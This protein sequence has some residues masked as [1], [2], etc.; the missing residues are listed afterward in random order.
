MSNAEDAEIVES[1]EIESTEI[2]STIEVNT[3]LNKALATYRKLTEGGKDADPLTEQ[4]EAALEKR[5]SEIENRDVVDTIQEHD[6]VE[7]PCEKGKI[8]IGPPTLTRFEK[9]RIMGARA[10]QLSLGAP[11][12]IPIPKTARI[13]LDIAMEELE[14]RV[15]PI[16][17]RRVLP[18][19]DFQNIPIDY[20]L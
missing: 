19:G 7:I 14:Q 8:T 12:F 3:G 9:A 1:T 6:P 11:P 18:N 10:L 2:E 20:F 13:S 4:Q 15:I 16:T 17:I 5:L